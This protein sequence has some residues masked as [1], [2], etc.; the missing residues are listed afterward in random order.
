[1]RSPLHLSLS[2][3]FILLLEHALFPLFGYIKVTHGDIQ[4]ASLLIT[5]S[6]EQRVEILAIL[7]LLKAL[8]CHLDKEYFVLQ[9]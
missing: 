2:L 1:M 8:E 9:V 6:T 7:D 3:Y 5:H 4:L